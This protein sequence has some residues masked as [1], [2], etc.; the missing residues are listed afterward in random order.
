MLVTHYVLVKWR[1]NLEDFR[2]SANDLKQREPLL[3][4]SSDVIKICA[5]TEV[6]ITLMLN[7]TNIHDMLKDELVKSRIIVCEIRKLASCSLFSI[8]NSHQIETKSSV[9]VSKDHVFSLINS[10]IICYIKIKF[11]VKNFAFRNFHESIKNIKVANNITMPLI[12]SLLYL[13]FGIKCLY[14][15]LP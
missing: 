14:E 9:S 7:S 6:T 10:I 12:I 15:C 13:C 2:K 3:K 5:T 8:L 11:C 1:Q 4:P